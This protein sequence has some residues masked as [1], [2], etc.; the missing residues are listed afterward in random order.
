MSMGKLHSSLRFALPASLAAQGYELRPER[1]EDHAFLES[2]YIAV[3]WPE[4][5][6]CEWSDASKF[7]FLRQQFALQNKHYATH[8]SDA[9]FLVLEQQGC[10]VGRLYLF[11]GEKDYRIVD[12]S[13]MPGV[14]NGGVGTALLRGVLAE[15]AD[16][17]CTASIH[18]EKFNP[19]QA[20]YHRLG[21]RQ[22]SE[23]GPYWLMQWAA[24]SDAA[25][26]VS[27]FTKQQAILFE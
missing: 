22:I 3:R 18:V 6:Q 21:F 11:R 15:A 9:E 27:D 12:I 19:A 5:A 13:L 8:Y 10:A 24:S 25:A 1:G 7:T 23:S 17:Q 26:S 14:R 4:L 20:L 2:L 16:A